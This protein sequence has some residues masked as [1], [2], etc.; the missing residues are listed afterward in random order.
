M[1]ID[2]KKDVTPYEAAL[3]AIALTYSQHHPIDEFAH[4]N[5][6]KRHFITQ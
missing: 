1:T 2:I 6:I 4:W 3:I 5:D